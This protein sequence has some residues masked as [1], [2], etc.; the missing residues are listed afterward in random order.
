MPFIHTEFPGLVVFEPIVFEDAR[1][2]FFESYNEKVFGSEGFHFD[3]VQDNQS[4]S[5]YGVV[6]GL[7]YQLNP[8]AQTKLIRVLEGRIWDVAVDIRKGSPTFGKYFGIELSGRNKLQILVP[9][10]FA[11][12]FSVLS[13]FASVLYK[14]DDFY[15]RECEGSIIYN[16]PV[17]QIDWKIPDEKMIL[18]EK[19]HAHPLLADAKNNFQYE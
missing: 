1:G 17:L 9:R 4:R 15:H 10:G 8:H 19:D 3:W 12:G 14:C 7:H 5:A 13:E 2:Y 11:H 16:D 6:R 18:S